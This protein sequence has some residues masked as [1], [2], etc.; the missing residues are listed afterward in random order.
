MSVLKD[1]RVEQ[2]PAQ[3]AVSPAA[4]WSIIQGHTRYWAVEAAVR[5]GVF[6]AV[7]SGKRR[8]ADVAQ[9]CAAAPAQLRVLLDALVAAGM[10]TRDGDD[11]ELTAESEAF[12]VRSSGRYMGDLVLHSPGRH[13]NW[14]T[15]ADAVRRGE[16]SAPI[17][18]DEAFWCDIASATWS[19]Q[20]ELASR[21]V[22]VSGLSKS[23]APL[24][25][26]DV[27]AGGAPWAIALL[28]A[29]P[30]ATAVVNDLPQV[31]AVARSAAERV[32]LLDRVTFAAGDYRQMSQ[33]DGA[34]DIVVLANVVRTEG[35]V[36]APV[37]VR[38]A[39]TWAKPSGVVLI[40]DYF[41]DDERRSAVTALF[42]GLT[43]MANTSHGATFTLSRYRS[44]LDA[45]GLPEVGVL[46]PAPGAQVL[47]ARREAAGGSR[48]AEEQH[49]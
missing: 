38:R 37:L 43:M 42:L 21:T 29:L 13:E 27:G 47:V 15:L 14:L 1:P 12:L 39:A 36:G 11:Y 24:R 9:S 18:D 40:A 44:W 31:I 23:D 19:V 8:A 7:A 16:P 41:V 33:P 45:A 30:H 28:E 49:G 48:S 2:S 46:E 34:F 25:I 20:H 32:G 22:V 4:I 35:E 26:L 3:Q 17:D 6:D 5:L 10:L